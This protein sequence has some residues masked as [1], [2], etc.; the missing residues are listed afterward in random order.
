MRAVAARLS[1]GIRLGVESGFDSGAT[2]D[3]VY[4]N[5]AEGLTAL[6]RMIDRNYLSAIGWRGIRLREAH[7]ETLLRRAIIDLHAA[8]QPVHIVD[9]AAGH[10]RYVL[11]AASEHP[12]IPATGLLGRFRKEGGRL[13][14][15][16]KLVLGPYLAGQWLSWRWRRRAMG[17]SL[18][19]IFPGV[20]IGARLDDRE[21]EAFAA[22]HPRGWVLDLT[23]D[24]SEVSVLRG[25]A[26]VNLQ[27][28]DL[29]T[30]SPQALR[31][32]ASGIE[33]AHRQG[34]NRVC[35]LCPGLFAQ[36]PCGRA[37]VG[38][39]GVRRLDA[40]S[41]RADSGGASQ[42]RRRPGSNGHAG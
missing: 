2:L 40:G 14:R 32:A 30:P 33:A 12:E 18:A 31:E 28:M 19:E 1:K 37:L 15:A 8:G 23:G 39:H 22:A 4:R 11:D 10:G 38:G 36:R 42:H 3:Y 16:A 6:G 35:S 24:F 5:R 7:L 41:I 20:F 34:Q 29:T 21:A 26:Y 13:P 27:L 17:S 25:G 9:I